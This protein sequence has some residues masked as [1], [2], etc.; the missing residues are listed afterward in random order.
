MLIDSITLVPGSDIT[1]AR[2]ETGATL[3]SSPLDGRIFFLT[4]GYDSYD[5]GLYVFD[6]T[7]WQTGDVSSIIAGDG[8]TGGGVTGDITISLDSG[9]I[10]NV[11]AA[12]SHVANTGIHVTST[13]KSLLSGLTVTSTEINRLTGVTSDIAGALDSKVNKSGDT[14]L[15]SMHFNVG[16]L[17][18]L[19]TYP[20]NVNHVVNDGWLTSK[21]QPVIDDLA[22]HAASTSLHLTSTQNAFLDGI[23]INSTELNTLSGVSSN[24][25]DQL[26]AKVDASGDSMTGNLI[27][28]SGSVVIQTAAP[29]AATHLTNKAYVDSKLAGLSWKNYVTV[30]TTANITLSGSQTIDGVTV[31]ADIDVRVLVK[32][33]TTASQNGIYIVNSGA[34]TRATDFDSLSPIDEINAA[35]VYVL[36]GSTQGQAA[37][38]VTSPVVDLGT[39]DIIFSQFSGASSVVP[40][41]GLSQTGNILNV[42]LG[43]GIGE[44]PTEEIG[45]DLDSKGGLQLTIDHGVTEST[46]TS[47]KLSIKPSPA[48]GNIKL[49]NDGVRAEFLIYD[50]AGALTGQTF[51]ALEASSNISIVSE[52][53]GTLTGAPAILDLV[54]TGVSAGTYNSVTVDAK[55]RVSAGTNPTTLA[56]Y[57]ITDALSSSS[58]STFSLQYGSITSGT[59]A[60][61]GFNT[62]VLDATA[63][64]GNNTGAMIKY[65]IHAKLT[66]ASAPD[67]RMREVA[68]VVLLY[69]PSSSNNAGNGTIGG[70]IDITEYSIMT[71]G[72]AALD[73][74]N[75]GAG[76]TSTQMLTF[77]ARFNGSNIELLVTLPSYAS[78]YLPANGAV[79]VNFIKTII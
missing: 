5:P 58:N 35:A 19:P 7:A 12:A 72:L 1:N 2:I 51:G 76:I 38:T 79:T 28:I 68:E 42:T 26:T 54:N 73:A 40:G 6:G 31:P 78:G 49:G 17:I 77:G 53:S 27:M 60:N 70:E 57:G 52:G 3:P 25:Q 74:L 56:G 59:W 46:D 23:T 34:W 55:G 36:G 21:V 30:A 13:E 32:N 48:F 14:G 71:T 61:V 63:V 67:A 24:V 16:A 66:D 47:A 62:Q 75:A 11:S 50:N 39:D 64:T 9:I 37:Y 41:I 65:T 33:Q 10:S 43:A 4:T 22:S 69:Y 20:T 29:T 45:I 18:E 8:L 15:G 44:L